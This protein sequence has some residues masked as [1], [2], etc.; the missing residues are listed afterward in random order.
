MHTAYLLLGG[1]Q[2]DVVHAFETA[3]NRLAEYGVLTRD[4]SPIYRTEPWGMPGA[5]MFYNQAVKT[6]TE[7]SPHE[8]LKIINKVEKRAGRKRRTGQTDPRPLDVDILLYDDRQL[9]TSDLVIPHPKLHLRRF[10]LTPLADIAPEAVHPVFGKTIRELLKACT[11]D[12]YVE[13][14][15]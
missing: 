13:R 9:H 2:G 7:H 15:R 11:D 8:L 12:L 1:N 6:V 10:A 14:T 5:E 3:L 4:S